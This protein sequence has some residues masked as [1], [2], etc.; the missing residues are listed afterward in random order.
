[1]FVGSDEI[2][3]ASGGSFKERAGSYKIRL[4]VCQSV[5]IAN[6]H[7]REGQSGRYNLARPFR[8]NCIGPTPKHTGDFVSPQRRTKLRLTLTHLAKDIS[9]DT[10]A[11]VI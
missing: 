5:C 1:L 2:A 4:Q 6:W 10:I 9:G 11:S 3:K 8:C 7:N